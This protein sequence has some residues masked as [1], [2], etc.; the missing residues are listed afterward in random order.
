VIVR[1]V[2][3]LAGDREPVVADEQDE[4]VARGD[5]GGD[6]PGRV[7]PGLSLVHVLDDMLR[8]QM[9]GQP[10]EEPAGLVRRIGTPVADEYAPR[11]PCTPPGAKRRIR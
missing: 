2:Q 8:A 7:A 6:R 4:R 3:A 9:P 10:A 11:H 5:R 1:V